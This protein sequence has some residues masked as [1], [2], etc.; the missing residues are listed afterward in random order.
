MT[1]FVGLSRTINSKTCIFS[2]QLR[3][4]YPKPFQKGPFFTEWPL[5]FQ[6]I[7]VRPK[8]IPPQQN[9]YLRVK[10]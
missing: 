4:N 9:F 6:M 3:I 2:I 8:T 10:W 5:N 7:I 1:L